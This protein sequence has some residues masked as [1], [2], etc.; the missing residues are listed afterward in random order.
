MAKPVIVMVILTLKFYGQLKA[1]YSDSM[2][3]AFGC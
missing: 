3:T 2:K 1:I